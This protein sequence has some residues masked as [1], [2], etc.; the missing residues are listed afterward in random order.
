MRR[1]LEVPALSAAQALG[2]ARDSTLRI[3][4]HPANRRRRGRALVLYL[5]WQLWERTLRRPWTIRLGTSRR[6]RLHPHGTVAALVLYC[7]VPDWEEM[8]FVRHHLRAGDLFVDVGANVGLYSVWA[9]ETDGVDVLAFEP[10]TATHARALENVELNGL[11]GRVEVRR[12][13]VGAERVEVK[14][15]TGLD[16]VNRV[17]AGGAG[18]GDHIEVV[19]QT[20]LDHAL[21]GR[22]PALMKIDVEGAELDVLRGARHAIASH[23]PA[24]LVEV[25]DPEGLE[26][27]LTELGY[28]PWRYDPATRTLLPTTVVAGSN[29]I[30][31]AD[32]D[33]A[34]ARLSGSGPPAVGTR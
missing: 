21:D 33:G 23:R 29:V 19:D 17:V 12:Q 14:L 11:A 5:A 24:L 28:R 30:A 26:A 32:V 16:A 6:L 18:A 27:L 13:A 34:R 4:R 25:N 31:L 2:S 15:T 7:R 3:L 10:S 20:T 22:A 1:W 9:T 8:S